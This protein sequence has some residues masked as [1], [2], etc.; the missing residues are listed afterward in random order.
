GGLAIPA[1]Q[2]KSMLNT[3]QLKNQP[4]SL[5]FWL[6]RLATTMKNQLFKS[7][8]TDVNTRCSFFQKNQGH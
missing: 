2:N 4:I 1:H 5:V 8:A 6:L 7:K 3:D